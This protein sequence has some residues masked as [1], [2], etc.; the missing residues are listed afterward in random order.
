MNLRVRH[1][2]QVDASEDV[3]L[4]QSDA[5]AQMSARPLC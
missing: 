3:S 1:G 2:G 4:S 5:L